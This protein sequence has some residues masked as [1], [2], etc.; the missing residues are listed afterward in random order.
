[1]IF[2]IGQIM[3]TPRYIPESS[4]NCCSQALKTIKKASEN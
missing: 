4:D 2:N 1:M 3:K